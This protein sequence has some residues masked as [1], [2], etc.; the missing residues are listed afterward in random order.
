MPNLKDGKIYKIVCNI[1]DE[2]YIGSTTEPTLARRLAGHV[3]NYKRWKLGK[4]HK[5]S[6]YDMIDRGYYQIYLIESYP[7]NSKDEL[8]SREGEII[9]QYKSECECIN[10]KIEGRTKKEY[11]QDNKEK[12]QKYNKQYNKDNNELIK[13]NKKQ[14]YKENKYKF[15]EYR[16]KNKDK[17]QEY[18]LDNKEKI[19][20]YTKQYREENKEKISEKAKQYREENKEKIS[21]KAKEKLICVCGSCFRKYDKIKH[22]ITKKHQ[23]YLKSL[24]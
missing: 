3:S 4:H 6:S 5:N 13:E 1:T 12:L 8:T 16:E 18:K 23:S 14:Y 2:C 15:Q 10:R 20:E 24:I 9:R 7:C 17:F 22:E 21:E 19:K 11:C